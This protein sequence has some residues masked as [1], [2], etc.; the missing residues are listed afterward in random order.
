[1]VLG[2]SETEK[3][4]DSIRTTNLNAGG[5]ETD[6]A[7][8]GFANPTLSGRY[9]VSGN[10]GATQYLDLGL[11]GAPQV[12]KHKAAAPGFYGDDTTGNAYVTATTSLTEVFAMEEAQAV[13][14]V[15]H[16]YPKSTTGAT[17]ASSNHGAQLSYV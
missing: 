12:G 9:R 7:S 13:L 5:K 14:D 16:E 3:F 6:T 10:D 17:A 11:S 15:V 4:T 1:L 8:Y 2:I